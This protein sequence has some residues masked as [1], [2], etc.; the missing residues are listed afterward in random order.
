MAVSQFNGLLFRRSKV[1]GPPVRFAG[2]QK[3]SA[4]RG[5]EPFR[6]WAG[7]PAVHLVGSH[8]YG[9]LRVKFLTKAK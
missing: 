7:Q 9:E 3:V 6:L 4:K 1:R 8:Q 2:R 5:Q